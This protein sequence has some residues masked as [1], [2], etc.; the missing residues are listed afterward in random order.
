[1]ML[2]LHTQVPGLVISRRYERV[3]PP[4]S[5]FSDPSDRSQGVPHSVTA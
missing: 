3:I 1:M 2:I 4:P 5:L